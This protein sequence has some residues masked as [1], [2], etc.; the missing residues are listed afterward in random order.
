VKIR[1]LN[2]NCRTPTGPGDEGVVASRFTFHVSRT[3]RHAFSLIEILVVIALLSFIILGL[4][5]MFDQTKRAF[6]TGMTQVDVLENGRAALEI[7]SREVSQMVPA[8]HDDHAITFY[9]EIARFQPLWQPLPG[10]NTAQRRNVLEEMYFLTREANKW[11][12]VGYW[13]GAPDTGGRDTGSMS[14]AANNGWGTLYRFETNA[15]FRGLVSQ[16][17]QLHATF[18]NFNTRT[19]RMNRIIDGVVHFKVR[20]YDPSGVW[21]TNSLASSNTFVYPIEQSTFATNEVEQYWFTNNA[22]PAFVEFELGVLEERILARV[23]SIPDATARRNYLQEQVG[24]VHIF[25]TRVP[26]RNVDP[27]AYQ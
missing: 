5:A 18:Y 2:A 9:A 6:T 3:A 16:P 17:G 10:I 23:K 11:K 13:V 7:M 15:V 20:A 21:I 12:G 19:Q 4:M 26:V 24:R 14:V 27:S 8:P 25:R 1:R 22:V